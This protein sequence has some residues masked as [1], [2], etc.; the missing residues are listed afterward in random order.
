MISTRIDAAVVFI[1]AVLIGSVFGSTA[2]GADQKDISRGVVLYMPLDGSSSPRFAAGGPTVSAKNVTFADGKVGQAAVVG[3]SGISVPV[4]G[5]FIRP[6]GTVSFWVRRP[7]APRIL[8]FKVI[9][10]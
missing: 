7:G 9:V 2:D 1:L 8:R 4:A 5:N 10:S 3:D 6:H